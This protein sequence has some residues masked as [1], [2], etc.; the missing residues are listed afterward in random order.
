[1]P[2]NLKVVIPVTVKHTINKILR[3]YDYPPNVELKGIEI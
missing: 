2:L 1:M 3:K